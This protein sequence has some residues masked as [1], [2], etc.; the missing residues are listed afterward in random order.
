MTDYVFADCLY[1]V[2][3][4]SR[5][6]PTTARTLWF[7]LWSGVDCRTAHWWCIHLE[8]HL[9][10][11]LLHQSVSACRAVVGLVYCPL[12]S[13]PLSS[14]RRPTGGVGA[15]ILFFFLHLNPHHGRSWS[16]H[17]REFDFVG[18]FLLIGGIVLVLLG[19]NFSETACASVS[20]VTF[21]QG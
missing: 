11:V 17:I 21:Q 20:P 15:A 7:T 19:F 4:P 2:H 9:A 8:S 18:L 13:S 6:T 10:V 5:E 14:Y 16:E 12:I 3:S 1:G